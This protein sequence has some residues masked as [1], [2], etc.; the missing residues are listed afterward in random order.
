MVRV[1]GIKSCRVVVLSEIGHFGLDSPRRVQI[2]HDLQHERRGPAAAVPGSGGSP[3]YPVLTP[4]SRPGRPARTGRHQYGAGAGFSV[5]PHGPPHR[6][7]FPARRGSR[8][9]TSPGARRRFFNG[10][11]HAGPGYLRGQLAKREASR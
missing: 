4:R 1:S 2:R 11:L 9:G 10:D 3:A 5:E 8:R 7:H 6:N